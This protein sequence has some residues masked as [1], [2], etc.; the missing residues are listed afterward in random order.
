MV[1]SLRIPININILGYKITISHIN[2]VKKEVKRNYED[3][4][5]KNIKQLIK[6]KHSFIYK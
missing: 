4:Y 3:K 2:K 1:Y 5:I 6:N